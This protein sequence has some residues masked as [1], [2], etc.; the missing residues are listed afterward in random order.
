MDL[1][2]TQFHHVRPISASKKML[3]HLESPIIQIYP[4]IAR[5]NHLQSVVKTN[6]LLVMVGFHL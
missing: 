5:Y 4:D 2:A 1:V 3:K 6:L